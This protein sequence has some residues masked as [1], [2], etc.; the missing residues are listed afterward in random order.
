MMCAV[1]GKLLIQL[2]LMQSEL[3]VEDVIKERSLKVSS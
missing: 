2:R 1:N 3:T